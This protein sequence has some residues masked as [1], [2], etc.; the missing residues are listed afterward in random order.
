MEV[1]HK[2]KVVSNGCVQGGGGGGEKEEEGEIHLYK[3]CTNFPVI[4]ILPGATND[5]L[6]FNES[7]EISRI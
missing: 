6:C 2:R 4:I 7:V 1:M 3:K 5:S